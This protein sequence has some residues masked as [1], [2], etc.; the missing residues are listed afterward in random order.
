MRANDPG[1]T[2]RL[3]F[4]LHFA[5]R[6]A[7]VLLAISTESLTRLKESMNT[8]NFAN[9]DFPREM[10]E[11]GLKQKQRLHERVKQH[12]TPATDI[13]FDFHFCEKITNF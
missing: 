10:F 9:L 1:R 13:Y 4:P 5:D 8:E 11:K 7:T 12:G 6:V 3:S 2:L